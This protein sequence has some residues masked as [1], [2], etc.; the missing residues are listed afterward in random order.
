MNS[1]TDLGQFISE[2][3]KIKKLQSQELAEILGITVAYY[4]QIEHGKRRNTNVRTAAEDCSI[5]SAF[6]ES[7]SVISNLSDAIRR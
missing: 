3:R 5:T 1:K 6:T 2:H 7:R 4:S